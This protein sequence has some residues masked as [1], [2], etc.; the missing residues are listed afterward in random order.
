MKRSSPIDS[1]STT[2]RRLDSPGSFEEFMAESGIGLRYGRFLVIRG[3][4]AGR[5]VMNTKR[6]EGYHEDHEIPVKK[7][8]RVTIR[9]G[10]MI[11]TRSPA[12][13]GGYK[14]KVTGRTYKVTVD[15]VLNGM[16]KPVGDERH[17]PSYAVQPP[18][19]RWPGT[20]GYWF[21]VDI[22]DIPEAQQNGVTTVSDD[23]R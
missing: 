23:S 8:D 13:T 2:L 17:N 9:K 6:F 22:N 7:G 12:I 16:N 18:S 21:E 3:A 5:W 11:R 19:V 15:H 10:T 4:I 1:R 14:S 20:G